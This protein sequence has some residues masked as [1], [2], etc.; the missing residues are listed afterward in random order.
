M[1]ISSGFAWPH[2]LCPTV[3]PTDAISTPMRS[4]ILAIWVSHTTMP[5]IFSPLAF[6]AASD[7][8]LTLSPICFTL[9]GYQCCWYSPRNV[10]P[11]HF[12]GTV[13]ANGINKTHQKTS[14]PAP[15]RFH[16]RVFELLPPLPLD[17]QN[18]DHNR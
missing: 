17:P 12:A 16:R 4:T 6:I 13:T 15:I 8:K 18:R 10:Q 3:S 14:D 2:R 5:T 7:A 1:V 9:F 11:K